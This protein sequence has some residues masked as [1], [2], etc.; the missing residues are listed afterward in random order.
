MSTFPSQAPVAYRKDLRKEM[1]LEEDR[2]AKKSNPLNESLK[3][4][5]TVSQSNIPSFKKYW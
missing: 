5:D 4:I 3:N 1:G 2:N